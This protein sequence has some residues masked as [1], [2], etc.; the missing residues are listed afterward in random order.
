MKGIWKKLL[1]F[2]LALT[3][4]LQMLPVPAIAMELQ[5][6]EDLTLEE[7]VSTTD[8]EDSTIVAEIPSGRDE[9]QKEFLLSNGLRMISIYGSAI[10]FEEDGEWKEIDNTLLPISATGAVLTGRAAQT[11]T[12][13]YKN[14]AG[15]WDVKLPAS[16][17]SSSAVEVSKDG[18]TLSFQ[19]AG[20][21]HNNHVVMSVGDETETAGVEVPAEELSTIAETDLSAEP[22]TVIAGDDAV[23]EELLPGEAAASEEPSDL[24][25]TEA[26]ETIVPSE[27]NS[28]AASESPAENESA[29]P[30]A[31]PAEGASETPS[32]EPAQHS[33]TIVEST[34][35]PSG[36]IGAD[37]ITTVTTQVN[38]TSAA[39]LDLSA[40]EA[41]LPQRRR[42]QQ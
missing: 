20:E 37:Q 13:A 31:A 26:Q 5:E 2:L 30:E 22:E 24:L 33:N 32:E 7:D 3:L 36:S 18:Y 17:S 42:W 34:E 10:H 14:T 28:D 8:T 12:V 27:E 35:Q 29:E 23:I 6:S 15:L 21:I 25:A 1:S 16:L 19:F 9:F 4:A 11:S 40:S 38:M 41:A 39:V